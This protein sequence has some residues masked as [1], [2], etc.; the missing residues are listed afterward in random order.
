MARLLRAR[1]ASRV[2]SRAGSDFA[3]VNS[4]A[5]YRAVTWHVL[6]H[7]IAPDDADAIARLIETAPHR[8]RSGAE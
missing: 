2:S 1:A 5:M 8:L 6:E 4:G 3:Y 7:G